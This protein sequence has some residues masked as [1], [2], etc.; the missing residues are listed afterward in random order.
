MSSTRC[1]QG[2]GSTRQAAAWGVELVGRNSFGGHIGHSVDIQGALSPIHNLQGS[3]L[4]MSATHWVAMKDGDG[5]RGG[6]RAGPWSC[7]SQP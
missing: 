5:L 4:R 1:A 7:T 3:G 6:E 2:H